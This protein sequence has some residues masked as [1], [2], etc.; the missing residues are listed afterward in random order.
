LANGV[1]DL[2]FRVASLRRP[3]SRLR[4]P[5]MGYTVEQEFR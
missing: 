5:R 2:L 1:R 3:V 4:D